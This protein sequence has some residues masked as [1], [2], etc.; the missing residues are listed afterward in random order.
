[1]GIQGRVVGKVLKFSAHANQ[2]LRREARKDDSLSVIKYS[3]APRSSRR[4]KRATR[5][6]AKDRCCSSLDLVAVR[7]R[8][9]LRLLP[10]RSQRTLTCTK[11][12]DCPPEAFEG[13]RDAKCSHMEKFEPDLDDRSSD[14]PARNSC[15]RRET[16]ACLQRLEEK[17][18]RPQPKQYAT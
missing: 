12:K 1:M 17:Y 10:C 5:P 9:P 13:R 3:S 7:S 6:S 16:S 4:R 15:P 2:A 18:P 14:A 11:S 8:Q